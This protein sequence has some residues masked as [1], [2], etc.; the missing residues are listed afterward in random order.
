MPMRMKDDLINEF[1]LMHKY[2][3][4][5]ALAFSKYASPIFAQPKR[6]GKLR[7]IVDLK[8]I[9]TLIADGYTKNNHPVNTLSDAA[10]HMA[11][12]SLF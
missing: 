1:A 3:I 12:K 4:I 9:N 8:K 10:R 11:G 2:E 7:L 6:N 5:T